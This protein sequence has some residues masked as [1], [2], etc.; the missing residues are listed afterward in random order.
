MSEERQ[1]PEL[2]SSPPC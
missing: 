1:S 2:V